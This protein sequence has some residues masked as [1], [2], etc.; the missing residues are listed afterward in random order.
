MT[1]YVLE[2]SA[3]ETAGFFEFLLVICSTNLYLMSKT[4]EFPIDVLEIQFHFGN[5]RHGTGGCGR[6][7]GLA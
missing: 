3:L 4:S 7:D 6:D 5:D 1:N 2:L